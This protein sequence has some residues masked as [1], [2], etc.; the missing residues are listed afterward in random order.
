L[1]T[2]SGKLAGSTLNNIGANILAPIY[3]VG[4]ALWNWDRTKVFDND[5]G[6]WFNKNQE[7]ID[8]RLVIY[9]GYDYAKNRD[10]QTFF[11]RIADHPFKSINDDIVPTVS[12]VM[13]AVGAEILLGKVGL[14]G[15]MGRPTRTIARAGAIGTEKFSKAYRAIRGLEKLDDIQSMRKIVKATD[16]LQ[17]GMGTIGTMYR[18]AAYESAMIGKDTQDST[19]LQSKYGYIKNDPQLFEEYK[20]LVRQ[21]TDEFGNLEISEEEIIETIARKI[22]RGELAMMQHN[23]KNAGTAAFLTN[24]PLVG[25]SYMIQFPKIFGSGFRNNQKILSRSGVLYG[26]TRDATGKLVSEFASAT[27]LEKFLFKY[28][29]PSLKVGITEGFE[30]FSQGVI[31]KGYSDYWASPYTKS[32]RDSSIGFIQAMASASRKYATSIE[33]IDS[34]SLG[35]LM[36]FLG[37]PMVKPKASGK[38]GL[39]WSG[40]FYEAV[41]EV[42]EKISEVEAAIK[43]YNEGIQMNEVLKNNFDAFRKSVSIQEDKVLL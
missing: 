7:Y 35:F 4:S 29:M 26:T 1:G 3:G 6:E 24:I 31:E 41:G 12:F 20:E 13:G 19:L 30:E 36:G 16:A 2:T 43:N 40:G 9:G 23:S 8:Q 10:K 22:P 18:S 14:K 17:K 21:N 27:K 11:S 38:M 5:V 37:I 32:A 39:G 28:A 34:M 15:A 33:G 42:S 25:A